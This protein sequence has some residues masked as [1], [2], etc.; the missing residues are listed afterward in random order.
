MFLDPHISLAVLEDVPAIVQ[1]L[2]RSYRGI[3]A[4]QGWT[5]EANLI[6]GDRRT[7]EYTILEKLKAPGSVFLKYTDNEKITGC[8]NL[9]IENDKLYLGMLGVNP[10]L[11]GRGLGRSLLKAAEQWA[12]KNNCRSIYMTVI[13]V[14]TEL[15]AWY[16][17]NGYCDIGQTKPF[18][19]DEKSG[20]HLQPLE[21]IVMEKILT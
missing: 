16:K 21:F 19:E 7:D 1:L 4:K 13:S 12:R 10:T 17:R 9:Q 20:R 15:I 8:V 14:R 6:E 5:H 11:Q 3:E 2:D 18:V